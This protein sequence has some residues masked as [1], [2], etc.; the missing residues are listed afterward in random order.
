MLC[1]FYYKR[2]RSNEERL[3]DVSAVNVA[4]SWS[5]TQLHKKLNAR[6]MLLIVLEV[7]DWSTSG[8]EGCWRTGY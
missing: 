3:K 8:Y 1:K 7:A 5:P 4:S 2:C 6:R